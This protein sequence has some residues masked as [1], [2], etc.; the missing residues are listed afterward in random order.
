MRASTCVRAPVSHPIPSP[1][2]QVVVKTPVASSSGKAMGRLATWEESDPRVGV[3]KNISPMLALADRDENRCLRSGALKL[4]PQMAAY[5]HIRCVLWVVK[6]VVLSSMFYLLFG[7]GF[8]LGR[9]MLG[10]PDRSGAC[11]RR[12]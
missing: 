5:L 10:G 8:S 3:Q 7:F 9:A 4:V 6:R 1:R 12:L 11:S 2:R